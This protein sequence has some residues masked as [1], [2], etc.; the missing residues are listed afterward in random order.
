MVEREEKH[1]QVLLRTQQET[2]LKFTPFSLALNIHF[3]SK[4]YVGII[5]RLIFTLLKQ[6]L[7]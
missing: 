7:E 5:G 6:E 1:M 4:V 3:L 2:T